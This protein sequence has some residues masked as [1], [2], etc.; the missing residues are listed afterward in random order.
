MT[1]IKNSLGGL[2]KHVS[3]EIYS[4]MI[5]FYFFLIQINT[6]IKA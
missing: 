1:Y 6:L 5:R 3:K 4:T 2:Q